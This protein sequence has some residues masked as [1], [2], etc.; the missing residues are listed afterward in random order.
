MGSTPHT[1][2]RRLR[3]PPRED[4]DWQLVGRRNQISL[5]ASALEA[6]AKRIDM[7]PPAATPPILEEWML[8]EPSQSR[9]QTSDHENASQ[10]MEEKHESENS[11]THY[12][13]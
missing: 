6:A 9:V 4:G 12:R 8:T 10:I 2:Q 7:N 1:P 3:P 5:R 11:S 13:H